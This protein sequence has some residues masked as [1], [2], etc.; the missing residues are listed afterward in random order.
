MRPSSCLLPRSQAPQGPSIFGRLGYADASP[1]QQHAVFRFSVSL[2]RLRTIW[3]AQYT[4]LA[5]AVLENPPMQGNNQ[6]QHNTSRESYR[7]TFFSGRQILSFYDYRSYNTYDSEPVFFHYIFSTHTCTNQ[8]T[9]QSRGRTNI[10][11]IS[12]P[13]M[14]KASSPHLCSFCGTKQHGNCSK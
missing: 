6:N 13:T 14:I 8:N 7:H 5:T 2:L 3:K 10:C 11:I 4:Q 1:C 9:R 12:K